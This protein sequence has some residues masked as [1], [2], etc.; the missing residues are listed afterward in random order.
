MNAAPNFCKGEKL[1]KRFYLTKRQSA[2]AFLNAP[3][4]DR[5]FFQSDKKAVKNEQLNKNLVGDCWS[6]DHRFGSSSLPDNATCQKDK[7]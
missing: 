3:V 5:E 6:S 2:I 1:I 7:T 4:I